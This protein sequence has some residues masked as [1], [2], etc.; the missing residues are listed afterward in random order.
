MIHLGSQFKVWA[1][2]GVCGRA[3]VHDGN[4]QKRKLL[5]LWLAGSREEEEGPRFQS[6]PQR[7]LPHPAALAAGDHTFTHTHCWGCLGVKLLQT[8]SCSW[9]AECRG[10]IGRGRGPAFTQSLREPHCHSL[11][12]QPRAPSEEEQVTHKAQ[13][14]AVRQRWPLCC[15]NL[16]T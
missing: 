5:T 15:F 8:R 1:P 7:H 11:G 2:T 13:V 16:D 10:E 12:P 9:A 6:P 4:L 14:D 3:A